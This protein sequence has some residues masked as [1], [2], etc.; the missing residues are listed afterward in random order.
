[1]PADWEI[2]KKHARS[3]DTGLAA[4]NCKELCVCCGFE[5]ERNKMKLCCDR[6]DLGFLGSGFPLFYN[7]IIWCIFI[8]SANLIISAGYGIVANSLGNYCRYG[9][10]NFNPKLC[11]HSW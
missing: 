11:H 9:E 3:R 6:M 7:F 5:L 1:M 4:K 2:A 10:N 8:L